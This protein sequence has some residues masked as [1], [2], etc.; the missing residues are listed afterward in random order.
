MQIFA[1]IVDHFYALKSM[2]QLLKLLN[3][4]GTARLV[5]HTIIFL[6]TFQLLKLV[7]IIHKLKKTIKKLE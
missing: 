3:F 2:M 1:I 6:L 5:L 4:I 7:V